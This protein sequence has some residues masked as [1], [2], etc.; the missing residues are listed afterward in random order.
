MR[1]QIDK[2]VFFLGFALGSEA[3]EKNS[4]NYKLI[5][6]DREGD[7]LFAQD[8]PWRL[9]FESTIC[10]YVSIDFKKTRIGVKRSHFC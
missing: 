3:C 7:W 1:H 2:F 6:Q 9:V 8:V 4:N 10:I 5:Y